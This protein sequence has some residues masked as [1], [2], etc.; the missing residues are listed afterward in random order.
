M[1]ILETGLR[2]RN[3]EITTKIKGQEILKVYRLTREGG[4][5]GMHPQG[6]QRA[7]DKEGR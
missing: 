1:G 2:M 4:Q 5:V 6:Q 7:G 3:W